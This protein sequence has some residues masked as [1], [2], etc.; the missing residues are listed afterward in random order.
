VS[1]TCS[2]PRV[3]VDIDEAAAYL[4]VSPRCVRNWAARGDLTA[5]RVGTKLLRFDLDEVRA[6]ARPVRPSREG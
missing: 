3:L 5:Y 2:P 1:G 4:G 6:L